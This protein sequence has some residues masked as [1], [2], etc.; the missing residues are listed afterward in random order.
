[1]PVTFVRCPACDFAKAV[2]AD[3][4]VSRL[5]CFCPSCQYVWDTP[6]KPDSSSY[7]RRTGDYVYDIDIRKISAP[8]NAAHFSAHVVNMVRLESGQTVPV[9]PD[10]AVAY[11]DTSDNVVTTL[12]TAVEA[13]VID[14]T[15]FH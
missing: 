7:S 9:N 8:A 13:W 12:V 11:G 15:R 5:Y 2:L 3:N 10:L 1:M 6:S 4:T 14:Q